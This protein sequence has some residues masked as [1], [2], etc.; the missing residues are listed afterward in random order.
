MPIAADDLTQMRETLTAELTDTCVVEDKSESGI[1]DGMGGKPLSYTNPRT[2]G[3]L[4]QDDS[5]PREGVR[6]DKQS[7]DIH[8]ILVL[9]WDAVVNPRSRVTHKSRVY[10]A[11][12]NDDENRSNALTQRI[13]VTRS[14]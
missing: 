13:R 12:G 10:Y 11:V 6:G 14:E 4:L 5:T 3:C 9:P 1:S 7:A 2:Y 8:L